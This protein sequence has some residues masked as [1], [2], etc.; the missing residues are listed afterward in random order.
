MKKEKVREDK[1]IKYT[2]SISF[3]KSGEMLWHPK[4]F[5]H[6]VGAQKVFVSEGKK[7]AYFWNVDRNCSK[8]HYCLN[9]WFYF[10]FGA[11][12]W[13]LHLIH[14]K[15][16]TTELNPQPLHSWFIMQTTPVIYWAPTTYEDCPSCICHSVLIFNPA[17]EKPQGLW[18]DG[19]SNS[20]S[21]HPV[22][23]S[24]HLALYSWDSH[25]KRNCTS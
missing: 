11:G 23:L 20:I 6:L 3:K 8:I 15:H 9:A 1:K 24:L 5:K 13:T 16:S 22:T 17:A 18:A 19:T 25:W 2:S 12:D 21:P 10:Y 4:L 7:S 14:N